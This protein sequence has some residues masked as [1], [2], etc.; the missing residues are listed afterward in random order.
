MKHLGVLLL[1][2]AV[3]GAKSAVAKSKPGGGSVEQTIAQ[4][5]D[6]ARE[7]TLKADA[8]WYEKNLADDFIRIMGDG[9]MLNKQQFLDTFKSSK[10]EAIDFTER[11]VRVYGN[12]DCAVSN[13]NTNLKATVNGRDIS[14]AYRASRTWVR[15]KGQWKLVNFQ[16]T[17]VAQ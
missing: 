13:L 12:G 7:A 16:S 2:L 4:L 17:R 1:M 11:K 3:A 8:S 6:A 14:G 9:S 15:I 5:E 10:Y